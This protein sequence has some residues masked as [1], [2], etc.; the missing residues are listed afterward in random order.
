M[1][2]AASH[3]PRG[4]LRD[5]TRPADGESKVLHL[6]TAEPVAGKTDA[7]A[8]SSNGPTDEPPRPPAGG[9]ARPSLKRVK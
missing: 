3:A 1:E 8:P 4:A 5:A 6:A 7:S 2:N 9:G